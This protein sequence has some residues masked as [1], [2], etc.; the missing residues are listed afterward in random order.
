M[1]VEI[2]VAEV[3]H[4]DAPDA[5]YHILYDGSVLDEQGFSVMG[6]EAE[7]IG[8]RL[9]QQYNAETDLAGALQSCV[10]SLAGPDRTITADEL[11]VAVL[12]RTIERRA[13]RRIEGAELESLVPSQPAS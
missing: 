9:K 5:L 12:D 3:G 1:E 7:A 13:F 6:G 4:D 2:L 8:D 10:S 11:E